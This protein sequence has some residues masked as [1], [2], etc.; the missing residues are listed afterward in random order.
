MK[1]EYA[2]LILA[3]EG[4]WLSDSRLVYDAW[5]WPDG[6]A[7]DLVLTMAKAV[8]TVHFLGPPSMSPSQ[9]MS[10]AMRSRGREV[11]PEDALQGFRPHSPAGWEFV[12]GT[13]QFAPV[14]EEP[15]GET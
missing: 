15:E 11:A 2:G 8:G 13:G 9:A 5:D 3:P 4:W 14:E 12:T 1:E 10:A 6:P 7:R